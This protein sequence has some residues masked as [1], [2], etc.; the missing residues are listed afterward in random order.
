MNLNNLILICCVTGVKKYKSLYYLDKLLFT[1]RDGLYEENTIIS[2]DVTIV[3]IPDDSDNNIIHIFHQDKSHGYFTEFNSRHLNYI[4]LPTDDF[5][6]LVNL[7]KH[8]TT[9][10][11]LNMLGVVYDN[12]SIPNTEHKY[13]YLSFILKDELKI[14]EVIG[15][16]ND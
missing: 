15:F 4:I 14:A 2:H 5:V 9:L 7:Y 3:I 16:I 13:Q 8:Y 12:Q 10:R 1:Y 6:L 11:F